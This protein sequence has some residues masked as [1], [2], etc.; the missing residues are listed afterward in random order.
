VG[1]TIAECN[2]MAVVVRWLKGEDSKTARKRDERN[3]TYIGVSLSG[4]LH[5]VW[6]INLT[7]LIE[8]IL[9]KV[10]GQK[11]KEALAFKRSSME[12]CIYA[13]VN[14]VTYVTRPGS[15]SLLLPLLLRK[16]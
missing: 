12:L 4:V 9:E 11:K 13:Y 15:R 1:N 6:I 5:L 16:P 10:D 3:G 2:G 8:Y 7:T 14:L